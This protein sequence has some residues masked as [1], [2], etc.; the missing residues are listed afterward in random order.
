LLVSRWLPLEPGSQARPEQEGFAVSRTQWRVGP[1]P[2]RLSDSDGTVRLS[3]GDIV[4]DVVEVTTP[5]D[6]IHV[7]IQVPLAAGFEPLNPNLATAASDATPSRPPTL[8]PTWV[9]FNDDSATFVYE[10]LP[11]G[12]YQLAFRSRALF[13]GTFTQPPATAEAMYDRAV[14]GNA[15]GLAIEIQP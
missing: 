15:R 14:R 9:A 1:V 11:R 13:P 4:E 12:T 2:E 5:Q 8:R 7:A 6:R 10:N 3:V